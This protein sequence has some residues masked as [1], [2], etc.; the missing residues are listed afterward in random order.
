M[1]IEEIDKIITSYGFVGKDTLIQSIEYKVNDFNCYN[2]LISLNYE[3][4]ILYWWDVYPN[5]TYT[6]LYCPLSSQKRVY[7]KDLHICFLHNT[8]R[9]LKE[10]ID[11]IR[12]RKKQYLIRKKLKD[13]K[14]DFNVQD[15]G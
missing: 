13:I 3:F 1:T 9:N 4:G 6:S 7:I 11:H 12:Y 15:N 2:K 10:E 14:G 5:D 8:I